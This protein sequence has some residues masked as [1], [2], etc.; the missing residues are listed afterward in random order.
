MVA[1]DVI[2]RFDEVSIEDVAEVGGK[3]ASLGEMRRELGKEAVRVPDGF[4]VTASAYQH[5][6]ESAG[7]IQTISQMLAGFD[8]RKVGCRSK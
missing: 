8:A 7:L 3:N 5:F 4:A 6:T 1:N 2:R